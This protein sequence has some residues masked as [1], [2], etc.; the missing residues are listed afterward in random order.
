MDDI[1]VGTT[2]FYGVFKSK[3]DKQKADIKKELERAKTERRKEWLKMQ[4]KETKS[5][6]KTVKM[7][8]DM[9]GSQELTHCPHCGENL[10]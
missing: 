2:A 10:K 1:K 8:E 7:M 5:L 3:L 9:L 4:L 6:Q